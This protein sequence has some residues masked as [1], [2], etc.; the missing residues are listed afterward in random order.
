MNVTFVENPQDDI[1]RNECGQNQNWL[2]GERTQ[3]GCRSSLEGGANAR[4]HANFVLGLINGV[5]GL[6]QGGIGSKVERQSDD[7]KLAL[8]IDG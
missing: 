7:R 3:E 4:R 5:H 6:A 2:I 1:D 8:M